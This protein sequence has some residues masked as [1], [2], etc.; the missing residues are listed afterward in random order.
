MVLERSFGTLRNILEFSNGCAVVEND[1]YH[2]LK[3]EH[4]NFYQLA[5]LVK[6]SFANYLIILRTISHGAERTN[7]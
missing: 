3:V 5:T 6:T 1:H 2:R 7:F 4:F